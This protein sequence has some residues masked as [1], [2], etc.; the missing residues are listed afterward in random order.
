MQKFFC[1]NCEKEMEMGR[2]FCTLIVNEIRESLVP[3]PG[4]SFQ[5]VVQRRERQFHFCQPCLEK[6]FPKAILR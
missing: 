5:Q 2:F 1:D 6:M 3:D 4:K